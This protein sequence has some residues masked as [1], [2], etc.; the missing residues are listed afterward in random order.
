MNFPLARGT[1]RKRL[2]SVEA[3]LGENP[4]GDEETV[5]ERL[6]VEDWHVIGDPGEP[7]FPT[8]KENEDGTGEELPAWEHGDVPVAFYKSPDG[9]V[10]LRGIAI[11]KA[12]FDE[13]PRPEEPE[14]SHAYAN[15]LFTLPPGYRPEESAIR[16]IT[17][18][19]HS[20]EFPTALVSP[21]SFG[22]LEVRP[23]G[24]IGDQAS[25][26][27]PHQSLAQTVYGP[28]GIAVLLDGINF[29]AAP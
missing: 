21:E 7:D 11:F 9:R 5:A 1:L 2:A 13:E 17:L 22:V 4:Q 15:E 23:D 29:R 19:V 12:T 8:G 28:S 3:V 16:V 26:A 25:F 20:S 24:R 18:I 14:A 27:V 6:E 10:S